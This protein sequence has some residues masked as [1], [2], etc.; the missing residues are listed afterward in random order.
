M[1]PRLDQRGRPPAGP[2][3]PARPGGGRPGRRRRAPP[4]PRSGGETRGSFPG[5]SWA[6]SIGRRPSRRSSASRDRRSAAVGAVDPSPSPAVARPDD[7]RPSLTPRPGRAGS[8]AGDRPQAPIVSRIAA[9][10]SPGRPWQNANAS[11]TAP[12]ADSIARRVRRARFARAPGPAA[13]SG[14]RGGIDSSSSR[15]SSAIASDGVPGQD[16]EEGGELARVASL[17]RSARTAGVVAGVIDQRRGDQREPQL[18]GLGVAEDREEGLAARPGRAAARPSHAQQLRGDAGQDAG[19]VL[20]DRPPSGGAPARS[21]ASAPAVRRTRPSSPAEPASS[22]SRP[23]IS[24][25]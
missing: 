6:T 8:S 23:D 16:G 21:G 9:S 7:R 1:N 24:C 22:Q 12:P 18:A 25:R 11:A 14:H 19:H 20:A 5:S 15:S 17:M 10:R 2:D 3:P 4:R 13:R